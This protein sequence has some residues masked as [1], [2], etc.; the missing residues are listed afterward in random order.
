MEI[1]DVK[2]LDDLGI[3]DGINE[4]IATTEKDGVMNAAPLGII[5]DGDNLTI[6]LFAGS[7]TFGNI[8]A[9]GWFVANVTHDAWIFAETALGDAPE[10][11]FEIRHGHPTLK[12]AESWAYFTCEPM[13]SDIIITQA[14]FVEG[15]FLRRDFRAFNRGS[16][17]V[18]ECAIAATRYIALRA[19][20]YYDEIHKMHRIINRCGGPREKEAMDRLMDRLDRYLH[21]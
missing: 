7:K 5:R 8:L 14:Q 6:R 17:L 21:I 9:T 1:K 18:V 16:N 20:S 13:R 4:V 10:G 11:S 15:E 3:L 19:D 12:D 2:A